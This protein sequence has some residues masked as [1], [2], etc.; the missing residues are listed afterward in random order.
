MRRLVTFFVALLAGCAST[1][2][3]VSPSPQAPVCDRTAA[4]LV[5]WAPQ[6]R[7]DQKDVP[8]REAAAQ[9]GLQ[10]FLANSGCFARSKLQRIPDLSST[11]VS[12]RAALA[13]PR[14]S[15][16]VVI[17]VRE[18]G[19]VVK[20]LSSAALVDGGTEVVLHV[21]AYSPPESPQPREFT[22]HWQNGGPGVIKGVA[23][24]PGDM[25]AALV[26]GLQP[27]ARAK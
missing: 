2:I 23:S 7:P 18:L 17:A 12:A 14:F 27:A 16:V 22:V 11:S 6:W 25:E 5:L 24:L 1:T 20:L 8:K 4:A 15:R 10:D 9:T 13:A 26:A 3:T 21:T 19:P